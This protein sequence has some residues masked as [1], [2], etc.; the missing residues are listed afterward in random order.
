MFQEEMT[1]GHLVLKYNLIQRGNSPLARSVPLGFLYRSGIKWLFIFCPGYVLPKPFLVSSIDCMCYELGLVALRIGC[2][3][4]GLALTA[5]S[6]LHSFI[7]S[8]RQMMQV[9]VLFKPYSA[10]QIPLLL[11]L[12]FSH[13]SL[14]PAV[15]QESTFGAGASGMTE[16]NHR[17]A[18]L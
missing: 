9:K 12:S 18:E 6:G 10:M 5:S 2:P 4:P 3:Q 13:L 7:P 14:M 15:C 1:L 16:M 11:I 17:K 8:E